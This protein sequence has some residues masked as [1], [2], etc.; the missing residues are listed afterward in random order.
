MSGALAPFV[1]TAGAIGG[2]AGGASGLPVVRNGEIRPRRRS[3]PGTPPGPMAR[4]LR[5]WRTYRLDLF[6]ERVPGNCEISGTYP[7]NARSILSFNKRSGL[8]WTLGGHPETSA[9]PDGDWTRCRAGGPLRARDGLFG[10]KS[11]SRVLPGR[12]AMVKLFL[13]CIQI[14]R[15]PALRY[16]RGPQ[17]LRRR[18][19]RHSQPVNPHPML[20]RQKALCFSSNES[21]MESMIDS[22]KVRMVDTAVESSLDGPQI[23]PDP[24]SGQTGL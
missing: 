17:V 22:R 14:W 12:L 19:C 21:T 7:E 8:G 6:Q 5:S 16:G 15:L 18:A 9:H 1:W 20:K 3:P 13:R 23:T 2:R 24:G 11:S 10:S 4:I